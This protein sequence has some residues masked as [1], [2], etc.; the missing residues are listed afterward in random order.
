MVRETNRIK[1][2]RA[3]PLRGQTMVANRGQHLKQ[4]RRA[5][6]ICPQA[7][8]GEDDPEDQ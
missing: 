7:K 2:Q 1:R 4:L 5:Q 6:V 8:P 3:V